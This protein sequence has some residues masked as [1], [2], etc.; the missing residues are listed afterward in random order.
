MLSNAIHDHIAEQ[1]IISAKGRK[2]TAELIKI[3]GFADDDQFD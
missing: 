3:V 2:D 1:G